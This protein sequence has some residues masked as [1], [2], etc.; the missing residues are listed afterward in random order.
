MI[1]TRTIGHPI[2]MTRPLSRGFDGLAWV[3]RWL[4]YAVFGRSLEV[5]RFALLPWLSGVRRVLILGEGDGRFVAAFARRY[6]E[7]EVHCVDGSEHMI[8]QARHRLPAGARVQFHDC[9]LQVYAPTGQYDA[10]VT[11][12]VLDCFSSVTLQAML[13]GIVKALR[14]GGVWAV[15]EFIDTGWRSR[16]WLTVM[17]AWFRMVTRLE[18]DRL[19][20]WQTEFRRMGLKLDRK[21]SWQRGFIEASCWR[22]AG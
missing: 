14:P 10:V 19:P 13:P 2:G 15:A 5:A 18:A 17:Y 6:P 16:F 1:S 3:Y 4:E 20:D 8:A 22:K 9:D 12:F 21:Q 7:V 11:C